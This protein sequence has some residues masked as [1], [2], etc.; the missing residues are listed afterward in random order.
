MLPIS[1]VGFQQGERKARRQGSEWKPAEITDRQRCIPLWDRKSLQGQ[2][3]KQG[4]V[5][6]PT[7][8]FP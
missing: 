4:A 8:I 3:L 1:A 6:K 2:Q 7:G 5:S